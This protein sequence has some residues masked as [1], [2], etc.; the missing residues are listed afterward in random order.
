MKTKF[1]DKVD[2]RRDLP[3]RKKTDNK[4]H[5]GKC[6]LIAGSKAMPG[7]AVLCARAAARSGA[8]YVYLF[9]STAPISFQ[10]E[11]DFLRQTLATSGELEKFE[12]FALGPGC[13]PSSKLPT[14]IRRLAKQ[15]AEHVVLDADALNVLAKM[16]IKLPPTWILTPHEGEL[17]RLMKTGS[18]SIRNDRKKS[19]L[20]AQ[21]KFGCIVL[22]K[23]H[24]TLVASGTS[25]WQIRSGNVALAKAGTGDV[26]TGM[27]TAFLAQGVLPERAACLAAWLH[28]HLAD[29]WL[30]EGR[31]ILS[32]MARDLPERLPALL[33]R[34]R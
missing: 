32:L 9:K 11:P 22:L 26:L 3:A 25:L 16:K 7:A 17:A 27:I 33:A 13:G 18:A 31:D 4:T 19:A 1:Y 21:K 6:L 29:E 2:A 14:W 8:G 34:L 10:R 5:G 24:G 15:G 30:R 20:G 23:G 28:G 12:A